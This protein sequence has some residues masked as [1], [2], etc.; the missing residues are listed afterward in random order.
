MSSPHRPE[1]PT[2]DQQPPGADRFWDQ[3]SRTRAGRSAGGDDPNRGETSPDDRGGGEHECLE[4]CPICRSAELLRATASPELRQQLQG[5]QNEAFQVLKAFA[6]AYAE[7]SGSD[8]F[9]RPAGAADA[10]RGPGDR[11]PAGRGRHDS[12]GSRDEPDEPQVT[13]IS[14]E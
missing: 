6:A 3:F 7:R 2:A 9:G 12:R 13:D 11:H 8:P 14:I 1:K 5:I 4:W 10:D